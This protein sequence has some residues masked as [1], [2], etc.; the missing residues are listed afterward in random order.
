MRH[1]AY[2]HIEAYHDHNHYII[3]QPNLRY[4]YHQSRM[5]LLSP[6]AEKVGKK[7]LLVYLGIWL[8]T[9]LIPLFRSWATGDASPLV[10]GPS[11]IPMPAL[12]PVWGEASWNVYG[13][14]YYVSGFLG[15][16]LLGLY[17]RR[18]AGE[19]SWKKTLALSVPSFLVSSMQQYSTFEDLL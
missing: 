9:T 3:N 8:F 17:F 5:P 13:T 19:Y 18:F 1:Q 11:G 12:Y 14:F 15:Y 16:L 7:E 4:R 10:H 2:L 6:W